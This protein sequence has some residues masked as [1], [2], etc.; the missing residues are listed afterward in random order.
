MAVRESTHLPRGETHRD[1]DSSQ[2][3]RRSFCEDPANSLSSVEQTAVLPLLVVDN[4]DFS[5]HRLTA[6]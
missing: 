4:S 6:L 5:P 3:A 2:A 1:S